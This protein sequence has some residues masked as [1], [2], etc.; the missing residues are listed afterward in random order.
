MPAC[1]YLYCLPDSDPSLTPVYTHEYLWQMNFTSFIECH[2]SYV[3]NRQ[4]VMLANLTE[5]TC[6]PLGGYSETMSGMTHPGKRLRRER[7]WNYLLQSAKNNLVNLDFF[8]LASEQVLSQEL[9]EW[10]FK[11]K[12]GR[13][14]MQKNETRTANTKPSISK[15][16]IEQLDQV[17]GPETELY[18]YASDIF[19]RRIAIMKNSP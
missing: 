2:N 5:D 11:V 16:A 18:K 13:S 3:F 19:Y 10:S 4:V 9:F 7:I 1:L 15:D 14:F 6:P 8:G 17:L 12:F